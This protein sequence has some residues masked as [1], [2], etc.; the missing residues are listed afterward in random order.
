MIKKTIVIFATLFFSIS[1]FAQLN[2]TSV[3]S[4]F[5]I[6]DR[7][8]LGSTENIS[9]GGIGVALH[10]SQQ[11]NFKNPAA[12]ANLKLTSYAVGLVNKRMTSKQ[13]DDSQKAMA[14]HLSY[15]AMGFNFNDRGGVSFGLQQNTTVGYDLLTKTY[16][17]DDSSNDLLEA[18]FYQG[19]GGTNKIFFGA[20]YEV[21]KG[22]DIGIQGNYIFGKTENI[23]LNEIAGN[24]LISKYETIS[25]VKGFIVDV[26][27]Q[28][29]R[30]LS[31]K[32][33][34]HIGGN[35]ELNNEF[36]IDEQE[37]LYSVASTPRDTILNNS[38][39]AKLINP[40][41]ST[42]GVGFGKENKWY[43]GANYSFQ[44][45]LDLVESINLR[46]SFKYQNYSKFSVGGFY[47]PKFNSLLKYWNRVTYRAGFN[48]EQ[49]GLMVDN[50][51]GS[52]N[53]NSINS[54]GISFG[55]SLPVGKQISNLNIGFEY[56]K[57]GSTNNGLIQENYLNLRLGL[58][59]NDK[60]FKKKQIF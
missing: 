51:A 49:S 60:W 36:D 38:N 56:G 42:L 24:S 55:V 11:I 54:F 37:Y 6:G 20:G 59:F 39:K 58:S 34:L 21:V 16:E 25:N 12:N 47:T 9:M 53:F 30:K 15:L 41:K 40:L 1:S 35:F 19:D 44:N 31:E 7:N 43:A 46:D 4:Y 33:N 52:G 50:D 32:I 57:R 2:N 5:G 3:Y 29:R 8:D 22:L 14:T 23:I 18:S 45:A 27:F 48:F 26:G 13:N 17:G 10:D 28:Y